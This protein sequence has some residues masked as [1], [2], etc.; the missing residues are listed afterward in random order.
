MIEMTY[1]D[2]ADFKTRSMFDRYAIV[3]NKDKERAR[4]AFDS[5]RKAQAAIS[6]LSALAPQKPAPEISGTQAPKIQ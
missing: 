5:V 4:Q 6:L 3:N 1:Q 2:S